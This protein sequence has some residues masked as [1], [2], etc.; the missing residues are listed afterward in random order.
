VAVDKALVG[1]ALVLDDRPAA[2]IQELVQS[3]QQPLPTL[4]T[5]HS[6]AL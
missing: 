1:L 5:A 6:Y 3:S 2:R 4:G